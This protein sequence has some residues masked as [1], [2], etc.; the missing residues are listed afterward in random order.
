MERAGLPAA[1]SGAVLSAQPRL[2]DDPPVQG[3]SVDDIDWT[4]AHRIGMGGYATVFEIASG[5]VAKVG[6]IHSREV[7]FQRWGAEKGYGLPVCDYREDVAVPDEISEQCCPVHGP[8]QAIVL[9]ED[10]ACGSPQ[11]VLVMPKAI[12]LS[13]KQARSRRAEEFQRKV[14]DEAFSER[15]G[16]LDV[17]PANLMSWRGKMVII[18]WGEER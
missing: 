7:A 6:N 18:D 14:A 12:S 15:Q 13:R 10:C 9:L 8:R 4:K 17:R 3:P 5:Y 16:C 1:A 11:D 2:F